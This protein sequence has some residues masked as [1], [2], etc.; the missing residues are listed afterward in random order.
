MSCEQSRYVGQY[1]FSNS[2]TKFIL[3]LGLNLSP[4]E[5]PS[6]TDQKYQYSHAHIHGHI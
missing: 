5:H 4:E 1:N 6:G 2:V 3:H